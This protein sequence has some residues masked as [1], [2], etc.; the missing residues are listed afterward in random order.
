[1]RLALVFSG[2]GGQRAE[3]WR[4]V[5]AGAACGFPSVLDAPERAEG[6]EGA[7]TR[8]SIAQPLIFAHQMLVWNQLGPLLPRPVCVAGYSLGEVA[9]CCVAG[10]F[11]AD[12]GI[13]LC[14]ERARLMDAAA[15]A[16]SGM[17]AV[18][19]LGRAQVEQ[20]AA[21]LGLAIAII[22]GDRHFVVA[23]RCDGLALAEAR[24]RDLGAARLVRLA[25]ETPSHT[26][27][28]AAASADF[29]RRLARIPDG[30]LNC[31][32]LSAIDARA[33]IRVGPALDALAR[34]IS[35]PMNWAL[36]ME[37]I[38]ELRPDAVLEIGPGNA[39]ARLFAEFE[40]Q[41]PVRASDDFR[42]IGGLLDWLGRFG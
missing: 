32:V 23:G 29:A 4:Q 16:G 28:M 17:L 11:A 25:V 13:R 5:E 8:N 39:L 35:Q 21:D 26:P 31:P 22:N 37:T 41:L 30:R 27:V 36:C 24:F 40:P 38:R 34:Q 33:N 10:A 19:G 12:E 42:S 6:S 9:A 18:I 14:I 3:H 15:P 20:A 7:I 1:M 2:Q